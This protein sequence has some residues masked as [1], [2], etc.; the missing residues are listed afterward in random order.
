MMRI[1]N[2]KLISKEK[3][4]DFIAEQLAKILIQQVIYKNN[5]I[6]NSTNN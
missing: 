3:Y 6:E 4:L 1:E 5:Q 2:K